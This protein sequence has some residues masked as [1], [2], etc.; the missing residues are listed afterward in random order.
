[1][2]SLVWFISL[3]NKSISEVER[4][5][6]VHDE[7]C[8]NLTKSSDNDYYLISNW[9]NKLSKHYSDDYL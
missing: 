6:E 2:P 7:M 1:M 5:L 3:T 9:L 8:S 4:T